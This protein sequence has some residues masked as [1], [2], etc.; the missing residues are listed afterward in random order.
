MEKIK[1]K[2]VETIEGTKE[3]DKN[4]LT[5]THYIS[6][7]TPDRYGE[8]MNPK[9][10]LFEEYKKNPVVFFGHR[11]CDLP[12][13]RNEKII[14][15]DFGVLAVTKF[16]TSD[17][18]REV[19]R[20][21]AEGFLNSWSIGYIPRKTKSQKL[22]T[23]NREQDYQCIEE[24][25]LLEYSSVPVPANPDAVNLIMKEIK[26][27]KVKAI[28]EQENLRIITGKLKKEIEE[29]K[30]EY[31]KIFEK[32]TENTGNIIKGELKLFEDRLVRAL[33]RLK[34]KAG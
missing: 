13:A 19:F 27:E 31:T 4:D 8:I 30:T 5:I 28:I 34:Y 17:F 10:C 14:V 2:N 1:Y 12:I 32:H 21:N 15:D 7:V 22:K 20:L 23:E 3:I 11:S 26:S 9:G 6:T 16:D 24:W 29:Q 25:E 18:A 33:I